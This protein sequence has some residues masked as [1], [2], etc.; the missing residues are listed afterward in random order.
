MLTHSAAPC[1]AR[2]FKGIEGETLTYFCVGTRAPVD[3]C[4]YPEHGKTLIKNMEKSNDD[5]DRRRWC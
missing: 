5:P 3:I 1:N 4:H 2:A